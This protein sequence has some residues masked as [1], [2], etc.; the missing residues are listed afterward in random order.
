MT[1]EIT[2]NQFETIDGLFN[3]CLNRPSLDAVMAHPLDSADYMRT[4]YFRPE[5]QLLDACI[6]AVGVTVVDGFSS[7]IDCAAHILTEA[8]LGRCDVLDMAD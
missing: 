3:A 7:T 2:L 4:V 6:D 5:W 1:M 8:M